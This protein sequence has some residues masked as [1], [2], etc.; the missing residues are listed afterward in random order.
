MKPM[1]YADANAIKILAADRM[2]FSPLLVD[3]A[4][5]QLQGE[6]IHP[7]DGAAMDTEASRIHNA[8]RNNGALLPTA[9]LHAESIKQEYGFSKT[10]AGPDPESLRTEAEMRQQIA[11][12][13]M[14]SP[15]ENAAAAVKPAASMH[16]VG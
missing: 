16:R 13:L 10:P 11:A 6:Q 15:A 9:N 14:R 5:R 1:T 2:G 4:T 7:M 8:L 3:M 12:T